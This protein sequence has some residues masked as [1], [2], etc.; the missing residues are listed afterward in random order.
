MKVEK[1]VLPDGRERVRVTGDD[2]R[3]SYWWHIRQ[4]P[5]EITSAKQRVLIYAAIARSA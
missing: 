1:V 4:R 2:G 3:K 5:R